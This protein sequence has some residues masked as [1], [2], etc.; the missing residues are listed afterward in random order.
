MEHL[1][2]WEAVTFKV[3]R[4]KEA[5]RKQTSFSWNKKTKGTFREEVKDLEIDL[6]MSGAGD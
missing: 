6:L 1:E 3:H 5:F 4:S 2:K